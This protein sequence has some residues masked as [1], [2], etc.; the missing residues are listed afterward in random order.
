MLL[1]I[2]DLFHPDELNDILQGLENMLD[3]VNDAAEQS[4][5]PPLYEPPQLYTVVRTGRPGRPRHEINL[6]V[7]EESITMRGPYD[8]IYRRKFLAGRSQH[9]RRRMRRFSGA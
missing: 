5:D 3:A 9:V 7:L 8:S 1:K 2:Q 6:E 4:Q